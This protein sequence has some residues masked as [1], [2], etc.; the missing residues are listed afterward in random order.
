VNKFQSDFINEIN[1]ICGF[2]VSR[3]ADTPPKSAP[4][5]V[6]S[7]EKPRFAAL[8]KVFGLRFAEGALLQLLIAQHMRP[9]LSR[10][11]ETRSGFAYVH[12]ALVR[13]IFALEPQPIYAS[14][15]GLNIWQLVRARDMGP[16]APVGFT[17][18]LAVIEWLAGRTGLPPEIMRH[19]RLAPPQAPN[20][21]AREI[22]QNIVE[23]QAPQ[24]PFVAVL[25]GQSGN[26][27]ET[28]AM[29]AQTLNMALWICD[30]QTNTQDAALIHRF[31]IVQNAALFISD[32]ALLTVNQGTLSALNF[33]SADIEETAHYSL[34]RFALPIPK[35]SDLRAALSKRF[36]DVD[37]KTLSRVAAIK[38]LTTTMINDPTHHTID[39]VA[40]QA[41]GMHTQELR[42]WAVPLA[43]DLRFD[44]LILPT[45]LKTRL[46]DFAEDISLRQQLW[47]NPEVSR[48][49]S[50]ER[51]L[52]ALLQGPPGTGKTMAAKVIAGHLGMPIYRVDAASL[53]SKFIGDTA[54]N[55]RALFKAVNQSGVILFVDEFEALA[56]KRTESRNE[57]ARSYNHDTAYFLQLIETALD[58]VA[59]FA[60]NR[61]MD[62]DTA[63]MR[64][65]RKIFDFPQPQAR[66]RCA[67]WHSALAPFEPQAHLREMSDV[68]GQEFEFTGARIKAVILNAYGQSLKAGAKL[69]A[70][71]L[72][73]AALAEAQTNGR[74]PDK[75]ALG[76][77]TKFIQ[78]EA[79]T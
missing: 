77:F 50:Q 28:A 40:D 54:K 57:I 45:D 22:A 64:R 10:D 60:T 3:L 6:E 2:V 7:P 55:M 13:D 52:T 36:T 74:I 47:Q 56:A 51:A 37:P 69:T 63:M 68:L 4:H 58:G 59:I 65:I 46:S 17:L 21:H 29:V 18:D 25:S 48:L 43:T 38:G 41:I 14:D 20:P 16:G 33:T 76:Q 71:E 27:T 73:K 70:S 24:Q 35:Q 5:W 26:P 23:N 44:D 11:Y 9:E 15:S 34:A 1:E 61:P 31:A 42:A 8:T 75:R 12:E 19:L 66:E 32:P 62:I 67:L 72:Y 49:Y 79:E 53:T 30:K 39:D 78:A